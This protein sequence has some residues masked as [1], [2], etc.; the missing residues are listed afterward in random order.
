MKY[1][2]GS[3]IT[4][5]VLYIFSKIKPVLI[6]PI[7]NNKFRYSQSHIH[8]I[9]KP[10]IP[11]PSKLKKQID[12]QSFKH[13]EKTNIKVVIMDEKAYWVRGNKF[14]EADVDGRDIDKESAKVVDT[15]H[16]DRVQLDKMLFIMDQLRDGKKDDSGSSGN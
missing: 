1:F 12:R 6:V 8:Q 15:M 5:V 7:T 9:I 16:M 14:Y 10:L 4:L 2:L 11:P 13:E 3:L